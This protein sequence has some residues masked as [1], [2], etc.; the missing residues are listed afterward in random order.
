[1]HDAM[2]ESEIF[3]EI[4]LNFRRESAFRIVIEYEQIYTLMHF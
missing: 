4:F 3:D 2:H 1:M